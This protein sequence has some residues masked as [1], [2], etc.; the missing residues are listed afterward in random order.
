MARRPLRRLIGDVAVATGPFFVVYRLEGA[1]HR[2][3]GRDV[4]VFARTADGRRLAGRVTHDARGTGRLTVQR[5]NA[6]RFL[7]HDCAAEVAQ[8]GDT[9][10]PRLSVRS[11]ASSPADRNS[12]GRVIGPDA[13]RRTSRHLLIHW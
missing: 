13:P 7:V 11:A 2:E 10:Y 5:T 4:L 12:T 8:W 3:G 1:I 9:Q 6:T